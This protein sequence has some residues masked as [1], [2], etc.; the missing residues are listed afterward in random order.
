[1]SFN[2]SLICIKNID[3][4]RLNMFFPITR[5]RPG[6]NDHPMIMFCHELTMAEFTGSSSLLAGARTFMWLFLQGDQKTESETISQ[7]QTMPNISNAC[8]SCWKCAP[9][10]AWSL[11]VLE[12]LQRISWVDA[13]CVQPSW[14]IQIPSLIDKHVR[15]AFPTGERCQC[16]E[17]LRKGWWF[18]CLLSSAHSASFALK[19]PN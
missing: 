15:I 9:C 17:Q 16:N 14:Y 6:T 4:V 10:S 8:W 1:M 18:C 11:E 12:E 2:L 3:A 5:A 7:C 13:A 19:L